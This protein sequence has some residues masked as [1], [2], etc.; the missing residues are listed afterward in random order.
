M[1]S[2]VTLGGWWNGE[3]GSSAPAPFFLFPPVPRETPGSPWLSSP[4]ARPV[5]IS[6]CLPAAP[7]A[8]THGPGHT[9]GLGYS[10]GFQLFEAAVVASSKSGCG[11]ATDETRGPIYSRVAPGPGAGPRVWRG[12]ATPHQGPVK[13]RRMKCWVSVF[14]RVGSLGTAWFG[15]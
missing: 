11:S 13:S 7:W 15:A 6:H 4:L 10:C 1:R 14:L 2:V 8:R 3:T 5:S 9:S 12:S